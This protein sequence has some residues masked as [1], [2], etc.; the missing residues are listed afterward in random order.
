M[1]RMAL[2]R[3]VSGL[4]ENVIELEPGAAWSPPIG[5]HVGPSD[6]AGPGYTWNGSRFIKPPKTPADA[7]AASR[8]ALEQRLDDNSITDL[9]LRELLRL[10]R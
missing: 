10:R 3:T 5:C 1:A 4:V 6:E 8:L 7:R 9:E 2:I